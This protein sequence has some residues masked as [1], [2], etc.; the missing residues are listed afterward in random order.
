MFRSPRYLEG[1]DFIEWA[2]LSSTLVLISCFSQVGIKPG[3]MQE[4]TDL[5]ISKRSKALKTSLIILAW[6][7]GLAGIIVMVPFYI[8]SRYE[9]WNNTSVLFVMPLLCIST[10]LYVIFQTDLRINK[11]ADVLANVAIVQTIIFFLFFEIFLFA[12]LDLSLIHI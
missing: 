12:E 6:T 7:G 2:V 11:M 4:V 9:E 1:S 10:N 3:Y 5:G 8:L